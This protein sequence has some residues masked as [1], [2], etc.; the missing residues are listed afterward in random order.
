MEKIRLAKKNTKESWKEKHKKTEHKNV[1][2]ENWE[3]LEQKDRQFKP[4]RTWPA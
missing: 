4:K 1:K 3:E 2:Q